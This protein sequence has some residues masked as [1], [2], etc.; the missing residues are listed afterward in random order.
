M[1]ATEMP[2]VS[3]TWLDRREAADASARAVDLVEHL[4]SGLPANARLVLHDLGCGTGSM[5]RWLA[6]QLPGPQHWVMYDRDAELL[7]YAAAGMPV[8][9]AD[10]AKVTV[11]THQRDIT[12]LMAEDFDEAHVVTAAALLDLLTASEVEQLAAAC[13]A[14]GCAALVT[15]SVIGRVELDPAEPLDSAID[16]AFNAHQRRQVAGRA[17]LGPDAVRVMEAAFARLGMVTTV[18]PSP[19]RLGPHDPVLLSEWLTG[20][21]GAACEQQP[22]LTVAAAEYA[23]RRHE[24]IAQGRLS[25][26]VHHLDLLARHG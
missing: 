4:R 22:T 14:A 7:E 23:A 19:W 18:R 6:P 26:V 2:R 25:A 5:G 13:A 21:L 9:A 20:W 16:E 3:A 11:E 12:Q 8:E 1:T 17:L 15:I 24:Q 10:G